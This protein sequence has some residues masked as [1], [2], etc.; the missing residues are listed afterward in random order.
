MTYA[1]NARETSVVLLLRQTNGQCSNDNMFELRDVTT[2]GCIPTFR[3]HSG[4]IRSVAVC[5]QT[6]HLLHRGLG[7]G[8]YGFGVFIPLV[9]LKM[10]V[11]THST[12]ILIGFVLS[13]FCPT[14]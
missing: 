3:S 6:P 13:C 2:G 10:H 9:L 4:G 11:C 14:L 12:A 1:T 5:Y 7:V 8:L